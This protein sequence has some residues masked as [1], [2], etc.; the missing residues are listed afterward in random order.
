MKLIVSIIRT[1]C[2]LAAIYLHTVCAAAQAD[3]LARLDS[4]EI[5]L[6]TCSPHGEV[7]S[8]YGHT[9]L[10]YHNL[11]THEHWVFNYGVFDSRKPFF[12]WHFMLGQTDYSLECTSFFGGFMDYYRRW[13][14][15]VEEQVLDLTRHEKL[16]L[17]RALEANLRSPDYR[18]NV[19]YDNC[20]TRPRDIIERC[21]D[22]SVTY[23]EHEGYSP[24]LRQIVHQQTEG[25]PWA[26]YGNDLLLGLT[27]DCATTQ[28]ERQFLPG[29]LSWDFDHATV[30]R[31]GV[32]KALVLRHVTHVRGRQQP[33]KKEFPLS[34]FACTL[35]LLG[36][37]ILIALYEWRSRKVAVWWDALLMLA[38][39]V[40][41]CILLLMFFS[42]H[43]TT[44]TNLQILILNPLSLAFLPQVV[45]RRKSHW[46]RI[47]AA[48]TVAFYIGGLWQDYADGMEI[49]ALCLLLRFWTHRNDK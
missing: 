18:Y 3:P 15:S 31:N 26:R 38:T 32:S 9:A 17:Q 25:H 4:V 30:S 1:F 44:S 28:R 22:G 36:V 45:R 46:F 8:L 5:G 16:Q 20:S 14:S 10:H 29:N 24:T 6:L 42:Q 37:S 21:L 2:L 19:F 27:A 33:L 34:P 39:G 11:R 48:L 7:Y 40:T 23:A 49:V 43:P 41:G 47:S 13:G 35:L 12:M